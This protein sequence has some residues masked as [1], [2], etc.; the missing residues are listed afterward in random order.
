MPNRPWWVAWGLLCMAAVATLAAGP[1]RSGG[2]A[3]SPGVN[4]FRMRAARDSLVIVEWDRA[5]VRAAA[6][7][8]R[9]AVSRFP[10]RSD[11]AVDLEIEP[12]EITGPATRFVLGRKDGPDIPMDFNP[13]SVSL[14]RGR[15]LDR[16]GSHLLLA[17]SEEGSTGYVDLGAGH[18]RYLVSSRGRAGRRLG[19]GRVTVFEAGTAG[20]PGPGSGPGPRPAG[21]SPDV[22]LCG[23]D[24]LA[25][26]LPTATAATTSGPIKGLQHLQL[27][28]ETDYE[29]F[30]LF[31]DA[32]AAMTYLMEMYAQVS[33][34]YI[35]DVDTRVELSFVRLWDTPNDLFNIVDPSP[36]RDFQDYW[37]VNMTG[38]QR[39]AA[40]LFSGR[41]DYPFG[42]Q[43]Y[44]GSLCSFS[45]YSVVG[46]AMGF[47]PDP[48][49]P[50]P[51]CYDVEVTAHELAHNSGA[52]HTH[53]S[54]NLID[55]CDDPT[56]TPQRGT[57]MSY[58]TQTWSGG[59]ANGDLYFH[60]LIQQNMEAHITT[61]TCIVDDC[62]RNS[63]A[64][65]V[66]IQQGTSP[67]ANGNGIP[68]ECEDCN[69]NQV[70]DGTEI[71][72]ATSLD[73]NA[74]TVPDA[75]EPDC[76]GDG[77]PD[78]KDIA[79]A[80]S[81]DRYGNGIPDECEADCDADLVSDYTEIQLDMTLD[82]D[83]DRVLDACQDC[84]GDLTTDLQD[85]A[86]SHH[87]WVAS[88]LASSDL[89]QFHATTGV[90]TA[91]SAGGTAALADEAQD[92]VVTPSGEALVTSLG[93]NRVMRF[94]P[95]GGYL[96][97]LVAPSG[98]G[99]TAPTGL[100]L[101]P[102]GSTLLV[103]SSGTDS[104]LSYDAST[105]SYLGSF[106]TAGSGGLSAPFGMIFGPNGNLFV[107]S[108]DNRVLEYDGAS[109]AFVRVLVDAAGNGGL[110][111]PRG[112]AFHPGGSLLV[113]SFG[114]DEVLRYD[115]QM[116]K[117]L[118]KWARSGTQ[119]RLTLGSPWGIR[120]GPNGNIFVART[121][122][123]FGSGGGGQ[124]DH[125][126]HAALHLTN[127]QV[128]EFDAMNGNFLR[129][130]IGGNDHGLFFPTGFDFVDGWQ[131]DCNLN[132]LPD[133]CDVSLGLSEDLDSTGVP[134]ECEVDCNAN[135]VMDRLD[136]I[137]HGTLLDCNGNLSPDSCDLAQGVSPDCTGNGIPD[138]CEPDCNKNFVADTCDIAATTS[139][140]CNGNWIPDECDLADD[141]ETGQGWTAGSPG[142][143]ASGGIWTL[144]AP[145]G[146]NA[147]PGEDHTDG[148]GER[149]FVTGQG[150]KG[151]ALGEN[152]VDRGF[153][154]LVSP[155]LDLSGDPEV[156]LG[157]WRWFSND[158]DT[159]PGEDVLTI[160]ISN[161]GGM[162]WVPLE[163]V[164][165]TGPEA[166]GGWYFHLFR[167][168]DIL[169]PTS[170]MRLRF[171]ASDTRKGAVVEAAIDDLVVI[172][173]C[174]HAG[175]FIGGT[176]HDD[177]DLNPGNDC[178]VC[179]PASPSAWSPSLPVEVE[180][181][182]LAQPSMTRLS[183]VG[184][185][186]GFRYDIVSG[187]LGA[188]LSSG[189]AADARC[190]VDDLTGVTWDDPRPD[191]SMGQVYYY[192]VR[193]QKSCASGTYGMGTPGAEYL[194]VMDC[195]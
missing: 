120:V 87:A 180:G 35:R 123:D 166:S 79:D 4:L 176:C 161:D 141:L 90:L 48:S 81:T 97:D 38:V 153:T 85:L 53:D 115:G 43:A 156:K 77:I 116:G 102:G 14:F 186:P 95:V 24:E 127:A 155:A 131:L 151:G 193:S 109:G 32:N 129:A 6:R 134:D 15:V 21:L 52:A 75:C 187:D 170:S 135:G 136:I 19:P 111:Q 154:T 171:V 188:L 128:Y 150:T 122:E 57:I 104:I 8:Q 164:G 92:L 73:L 54:P 20:R 163:T 49:R 78:D 138:E 39:D 36:L 72:M 12:F 159:N 61:R 191:P 16:P 70:L 119:D 121:G 80:T 169:A 140:D 147:Q 148:A 17:F 33:D 174:C 110:D 93:D 144:V 172:A 145:I 107:T 44:L 22:P 89:R 55:T 88:G 1:R 99:L 132:L 47:F 146:T 68:D 10:L 178:E 41:R 46:Y 56:T 2:K 195:P 65:N 189:T 117:A 74:D 157:Y 40:Q 114:T 60:S 11:L 194:P 101:T 83:R 86:G 105:G 160:D 190:V 173:G 124:H 125:D 37:N 25:G 184:Q 149:C 18:K 82:L 26:P 126:D 177:Q 112:L 23:A 118:G 106:V 94:D 31:G 29:F 142:D 143:T 62:N 185:S 103:A 168:A 167:V 165:P 9:R 98:G 76:N 130:Y 51:Y 133:S 69:G 137:P 100:T 162:S 34:I 91:V 28:V 63:V 181:L 45:A 30:I 59:N 27:A 66:D 179:D 152:D 64:D 58:C 113:A 108:D 13:S 67:D 158:T 84:D 175:C 7:S 96:G 192:L 71:A 183:W 139:T 182:A 50:S 42:G 3:G 5:A